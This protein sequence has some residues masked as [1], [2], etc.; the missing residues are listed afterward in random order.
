M[1]QHE[2]PIIFS[3]A[4]DLLSTVSVSEPESLDRAVW[5][6]VCDWDYNHG[7]L[8]SSRC[9]AILIINDSFSSVTLNRIDLGYGKN[10]VILGSSSG[11]HEASKTI[12]PKDGFVIVFVWA[13][14]PSPIEVGHLNIEISTSAFTALIGSRPRESSC[15]SKTGFT[16]GFL[17]KTV[18]EWWSKFVVVIN[19]Y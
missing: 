18:S 13:H 3:R 11:Y 9:S 6:L 15:V 5:S 4:R 12:L 17:E 2:E 14:R 7:G 1:E 19:A 10:Y 16:T 8:Q